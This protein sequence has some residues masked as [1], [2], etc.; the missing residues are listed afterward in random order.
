MRIFFLKL[1]IRGR[2]SFKDLT[3]FLK[4]VSAEMKKAVEI[5]IRTFQNSLF[6]CFYA[7]EP[8]TV[9]FQH[10][11]STK[12]VRNRVG[13]W[14]ISM[15]FRGKSS[16]FHKCVWKKNPRFLNWFWKN[17]FCDPKKI[18]QKIDSIWYDVKHIQSRASNSKKHARYIILKN[19][20]LFPEKA[21][22]YFQEMS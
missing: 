22:D 19:L 18:V 3:H 4:V 10:H 21:E 9:A 11:F 5:T 7:L 12:S 6:L 17:I 2:A 15:E 1:S 8:S 16:I 13:F 20:Q 14:R